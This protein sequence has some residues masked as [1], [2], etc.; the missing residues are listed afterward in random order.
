MGPCGR[1]SRRAEGRKVVW[2]MPGLKLKQAP[3]IDKREDCYT[4]RDA[5]NS[6][7]RGPLLSSIPI[8]Y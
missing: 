3:F 8:R 2:C 4:T 5:H 7:M 1:D 6:A